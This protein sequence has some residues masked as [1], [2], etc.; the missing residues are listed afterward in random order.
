MA[1]QFQEEWLSGWGNLP[2]Q[3]CSVADPKNIE[4]LRCTLDSEGVSEVAPRGL[5]RSYGDSALHESVIRLTRCNRFLSFDVE[6][7]VILCQAGVSLEDIIN[8]ALP[9]GWFLPT[10]PGTKY[11]TLGGAVAADVHGKN[12]HRDGSLGN[13]V[14]HMTLLLASGEEVRCSPSKRSDV[15]WSTVGGMGLTGIILT[16]ELQLRRV[17]SAFCQVR[18]QRTRCLDDTLE[19]FAATNDQY[20]HSVAWIDCL[21]RGESLGRSVLMLAN[22]AAQ[23]DLPSG[24]WR[25]PLVVPRRRRKLVPFYFP[26]FTLNRW[27]VRQFNG[28]YYWRHRDTEKLV[29]FDR[30]FYPLDGI[31]HWN[32][33]Y[34]RRGFTQYQA[35]F[36]KQKSREGLVELLERVSESGQASFLAVLKSCGPASEGMLSFLYPGHTI[37]LDLP[38]TGESLTSLIAELDEIVLRHDGRLY[39][40]KDA[41]MNAETFAAMYPRAD[42]FRE[43]KR[44]LDP[45]NVFVTAQARRVGLA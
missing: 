32:R 34:G 6:S 45:N 42:E 36:P 9:Q 20:E 18:Y 11:V 37:A 31:R 43:T 23:D 1:A 40:A 30:F 35:L 28:W 33:L 41:F 27:T 17:E 12:H 38:N 21:S 7:G 15:F 24:K 26:S 5:G 4:Q 19:A 25:D 2:R 3:R 13:F 16:V 14:R 22:D 10:T 39:L 29:D 44:Q 8:V